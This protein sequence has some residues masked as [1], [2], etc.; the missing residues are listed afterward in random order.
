LSF[1]AIHH[2]IQDRKDELYPTSF[3]RVN[4][5][6]AFTKLSFRL[7]NAFQEAVSAFSIAWLEAAIK[8]A[9]WRRI[10]EKK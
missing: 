10:G 1:Q 9:G 6:D 5:G 7:E 4:D 2:Q 3:H 8:R